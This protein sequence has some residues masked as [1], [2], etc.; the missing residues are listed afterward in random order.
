MPQFIPTKSFSQGVESH[1]GHHFD[2]SGGG[3]RGPDGQV[4][5]VV[6]LEAA[7]G[8]SPVGELLDHA[9][10]VIH[11][12]V[13]LLRQFLL[14]NQK[15]RRIVFGDETAGVRIVVLFHRE[16]RTHIERGGEDE[17]AVVVGVVADEV[18]AAGGEK[19]VFGLQHNRS[20]T[21]VETWHAASRIFRGQRY[22][23]L[24]NTQKALTIAKAN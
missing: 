13:P 24:G 18:H 1:G 16:I 21:L 2:G 9:E 14:A 5:A 7:H 20:F 10:R 4:A 6:E 17:S 22:D 15:L 3:E 8:E 19:V 23:F 12:A 11:P